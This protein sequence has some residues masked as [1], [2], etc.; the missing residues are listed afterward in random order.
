MIHLPE[1]CGKKIEVTY[2]CGNC[3]SI[4]QYFDPGIEVPPKSIGIFPW[5][6]RKAPYIVQKGIAKKKVI[7]TIYKKTIGYM[8]KQL[9]GVYSITD[10]KGKWTFKFFQK[11]NEFKK[12]PQ[13]EAYA[14]KNWTWF[15][16]KGWTQVGSV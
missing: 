2:Q 16:P 7:F 4:L 12:L 15:V 6:M 5:N 9:M 8:K 3:L 13:Y 14:N 1:L 11:D 10:G